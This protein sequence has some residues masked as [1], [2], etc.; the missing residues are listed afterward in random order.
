MHL[1]VAQAL[2]RRA[3]NAIERQNWIARWITWGE[4]LKISKNGLKTGNAGA[5]VDAPF[6][7]ITHQQHRTPFSRLK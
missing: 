2:A 6:V 3:E 1:Y 5:L 7:E 4:E